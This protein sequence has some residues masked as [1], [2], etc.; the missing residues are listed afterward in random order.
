VSA[1]RRAGRG[2]VTLLVVAV[3]VTAAVVAGALF[4]RVGGLSGVVRDPGA[5]PITVGGAAPAAHQAHEHHAGAAAAPAEPDAGPG[6]GGGLA[7]ASDAYVLSPGATRFQ[8]GRAGTFTFRI[9][10][11]SGRPV[12]SFQREHTKLLHLIVVRRDLTG[13]QHLHPSLAPGGTWTTRLTL[14]AA[15]AYRAFT[16]FVTG[17]GAQ[18]LGVDLFAGGQ[19][20][21]ATLPPPKATADVAGYQVALGA[22]PA[23][24]GKPGE[25]SFQVSRDG[26]TVA[27]LEPYLGARGHLVALRA[28]DMAYL[29]VHPEDGA[30]PG[31]SIRFHATFP[32]AGSYR[33]FLQF[34]HAGI[35]HT[36]AFT[37]NVR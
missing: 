30:T 12:T 18:T 5:P 17:T 23:A 27:D 16:D 25:L 15:G 33:L 21:A 34:Q 13:Y 31:S 32:S 11:R 8:T 1:V 35:V 14:P 24:A 26:W 6:Q 4:Q 7:V 19:F 9:L 10:D 22:A 28:G 20:Q 29:H 3:I 2:A 37:L 36:A